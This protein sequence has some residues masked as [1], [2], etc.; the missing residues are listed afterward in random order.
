[1]AA[2]DLRVGGD[3]LR[4][5]WPGGRLG[6]PVGPARLVPLVGLSV[7]KDLIFTGRVVG[8]EEALSPR[9]GAPHGSQGGRASR[10]RSTLAREVAAH[11]PDGL[12]RLKRL[13][14]DLGDT[15]ARGAREGEGLVRLAAPRRGAAVPRAYVATPPARRD[16]VRPP[17]RT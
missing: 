5:A 11:P 8:L 15:A 14:A 7:A 17:A 13:F 6:V 3:N 9:P 16:A 10:R 4:L 2:C 12:R 1:M